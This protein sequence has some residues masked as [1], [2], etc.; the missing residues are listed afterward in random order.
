MKGIGLNLSDSLSG[1][2]SDPPFSAPS[3]SPSGAPSGSLSSAPSGSL[4]SAPSDPPFSAPSDSPV[5]GDQPDSSDPRDQWTFP[6]IYSSTSMAPDTINF[7]WL[8]LQGADPQFATASYEV[9]Y[10]AGADFAFDEAGVRSLALSV[11]QDQVEILSGLQPDTNYYLKMRAKL[12]N[13]TFVLPPEVYFT[14]SK[15]IAFL[16]KFREGITHKDLNQLGYED[17]RIDVET[18]TVLMRSNGVLGVRLL[19]VHC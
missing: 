4:S 14:S 10:A 12:S 11:D 6:G 13:G 8:P 1:A 16:P 7:A 2:P 5:G 17:I 19:Q 18:A 9:Q 15:T 3:D